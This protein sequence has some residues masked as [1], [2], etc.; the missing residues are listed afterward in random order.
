MSFWNWLFRRRRRE[1]DL[2][3]EVQAHLRM[4]AH[5]HAEQG[6]TAEEARASVAREFGNVELV[7]EVTRDVWGV[8]WLETLGQDLRYGTR[9]LRKNPG[10]TAVAVFTLALGIGANTAMFSVVNA[11][12]FDPLPY[13]EPSRLVTLWD[14]S[15]AFGSPAPGSM[16]D[17]DYVE[18][19]AQNQV[20]DDA[21]AF[22]GQTF[23]LTGAG[24]PE[25]LLG[26]SVSPHLF[27]L[28]GVAPALGRG[29]ASDEEQAGQGNVVLLSYQLWERRFGANPAAVGKSI[30]LDGASFTVV[31]VMPPFFD[32]P[33]QSSI[34]SPLV[35]TSDQSNAMDKIVARLKPGV[36]LE[37]ARKDVAVIGHRLNQQNH[38][39]DSGE[40]G[41]SLVFLQDSM[42]SKIRPA[43]IVLLAAV[44]LVLLIAFVNVANLL[45]ARATARQ[46]E[47]SVRFALGAS[48]GR[49]LRQ[50]LTESVL[51]AVMGGSLGMLLAAWCR[52][53]L[54]S[55]MP[56]SL[57]EPGIIGRMTT[58]H[59]DARVFGFTLLAS[60]GGAVL[61][62]L[63]AGLKVSSTNTQPS[64]QQAAKTL[65]PSTH[66]LSLRNTLVVAEYALTLVLLISAGLLIKS[67]VRLMEVDPGFQPERVL[68]ANLE[69]PPTQYQTDTQMK[70]FHDSVMQRIAS[71]PGVRAVGT[72]SYGL[73]L[74]GGGLLGDFN[75]E[76]LPEP[77][78]SMVNKLVVSSGYF[79]AMGIRIE[80]GREFDEHDGDKSQ[81]VAIVSESVAR[82]FWPRG[83]ALGKRLHLGF[84]GSPWYSAVGVAVD[85]KQ[86]GLEKE[87]PL[88][89]Y[90]P[91][92]QAPRSFFLS[93]MTIATRTDSD[94][95]SMAN[96][97]RHA[98]RAV[99]PNMPLFDVTSMEQL[100]YQ[101]VST[102]RFNAFLLAGFASLALVLAVV[103]IYGVTSYSVTQR[104]HEIGIRM[105][106]GAERVDV[107]RMVVRQGLRLV[108]LGTAIG[109][110]AAFA[111][112]KVLRTMLFAV[113]PTDALTYFTVA[114]ALIGVSLLATCIPARR[115]T[116]VD[117][118]VALRYE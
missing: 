47:I 43:L 110:V 33:N 17:P 100:V 3:E 65:T 26:A 76:G 72:V 4:A 62:G 35:L 50:G 99:D 115:A 49:I 78:H 25:R 81:P 83:D 54:V 98:V 45:L 93:F 27:H 79:R 34:W 102:P 60:L 91:Y 103:G 41:F 67:F 39:P 68:I 59:L 57:A 117:P 108:G 37:R 5:E 46:H 32:F 16:T 58:I 51:L 116:K 48:R 106:L 61:F 44:G 19:R 101:S 89:I 118:L 8:R 36:T 107:L 92:S 24:E 105:A 53:F 42:V 22:H 21:A 112:T 114:A 56:Q 29:F 9:Q 55:L 11:V 111:V 71:L 30:M 40:E 96:A 28:L 82:R 74:Y 97:L 13:R 2:D 63:V 12:L 109:V 84:E 70:E 14:T 85:V 90:V 18:L 10:F 104:T 75:I 66:L 31:G 94:P 69:L 95:L 87:A 86:T 88:A 7:K 38:R 73:P 77:P 52:N 80:E 6:E 1:E 64:L 15:T 113:Q 20:F 23:N